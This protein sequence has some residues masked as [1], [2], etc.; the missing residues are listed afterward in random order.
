VVKTGMLFSVEIIETLAEK[1][2]LYVKRILVLDPVMVAKGGSSLI[3]AAAVAKL[4]EKL[5]PC[6]YLL[7]PNIPEAESLTGLTIR[8]EDDM[9]LVA[10]ELHHMGARNVL[11]KGGHLSGQE[12]TDILFD[13]KVVRRYAA[14]RI[15]TVNTHGTGCT[16]ASAIAAFLAQGEPLPVAVAR[17]KQFVTEAIR[18]SVPLGSGHGPVNHL[19]AAQLLMGNID[20]R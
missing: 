7:T 14:P 12:A 11:L 19:A 17:A 18:L 6:A 9:E 4:V 13:G 3:D 1:L 10:R 8:D 16:Y 20:N 5:L 2:G 15:D